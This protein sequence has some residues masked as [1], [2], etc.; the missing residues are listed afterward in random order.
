[1]CSYDLI[2]FL[3]A[4]KSYKEEYV[5]RNYENLKKIKDGKRRD[6]ITPHIT[7]G[8]IHPKKIK[9]IGEV[10][11]KYNGGI[12]ITSGQRILITNLKEEDLENIWKDLEMEPAVKSQNSLK[13][14]EICPAN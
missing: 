9:K 6:G 11:K 12:K 2:A 7:G 5:V 14:V 13:N 1:M 4:R 8:I 10:N 3:Y